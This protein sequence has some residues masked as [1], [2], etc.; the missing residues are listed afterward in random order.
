ME[1]WHPFAPFK[2][3]TTSKKFRSKTVQHI[4]WI[5]L[6]TGCQKWHICIFLPIFHQLL[7]LFY[8]SVTTRAIFNKNVCIFILFKRKRERESVTGIVHL[9][10][11]FSKY[12]KHFELDQTIAKSLE[13]MMD[14]HV[15]GRYSVPNPVLVASS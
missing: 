15:G 14:L 1:G 12:L 5:G 9:L 2:E 8:T 6:C 10:I 7:K 11:H 4:T 13:V 3:L